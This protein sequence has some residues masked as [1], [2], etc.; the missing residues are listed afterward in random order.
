MVSCPDDRMRKEFIAMKS[1]DFHVPTHVYF[2]AGSVLK[3]KDVAA[4]L[5]KKALLVAAR[6]SMRTSGILGQVE[7]LLRDGGDEI[8]SDAGLR[9][10]AVG[11]A[12]LGTAEIIVD[13]AGTGKA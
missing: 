4:S 1:F 5:G 10:V 11:D 3:V 12:S 6:D 7:G 8:G 9:V 2:G 13:A